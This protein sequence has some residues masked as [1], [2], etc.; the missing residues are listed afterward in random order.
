ME[1]LQEAQKYCGIFRQLVV[2]KGSKKKML[3]T[4]RKSI[5]ILGWEEARSWL[6]E[7]NFRQNIVFSDFQRNILRN[8]FKR[9]L[10]NSNFIRALSEK[11]WLLD[12]VPK[13]YFY[14]SRRT[15]SA[16]KKHFWRLWI[17]LRPLSNNV[18]GW[19]SQNWFLC[20]QRNIFGKNFVTKYFFQ[21]FWTLS[22]KLFDRVIETAF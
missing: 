5:G 21:F 22:E 3:K 10:K 19:C 15:F 14:E 9:I 11:C 20:V 1:K 17:F 18:F 8:V 4:S 12:D 2:R 6:S 13:K 16:K 7:Y